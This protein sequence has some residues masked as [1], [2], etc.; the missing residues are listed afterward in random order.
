[1]RHRKS[2]RQ[3]NRNSSHRQAMF[4][5]MASSL[6]RHEII[7]T[8]L[9]KAKE[10]RRVVEPLITMA[11]QDSVANRRLAFA[12]TRDKEVVGKLFNELGPRYE[13][14]PGGYTR[15]MKCGFRTGDNAPM[16][17]IELVGRPEVEE[18]EEVAEEAAE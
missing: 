8:T 4:R 14:R 12:R 7:K 6:V 9:P 5:N 16:A 2:G 18:V 10:L 11:K 13:E 15:I 1:M 17:Y 3:L